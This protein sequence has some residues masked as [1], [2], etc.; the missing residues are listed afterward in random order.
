MTLVE[1]I[2]HEVELARTSVAQ[3]R[4]RSG[5][6]P[7]PHE[8]NL[9][10]C[11]VG[12]VQVLLL[13][14]TPARWVAGCYRPAGVIEARPVKVIASRSIRNSDGTAPSPWLHKTVKCNVTFCPVP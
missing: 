2:I 6:A 5:N 1:T 8:S 10:T 14:T 11:G 3:D 9:G 12:V 13:A 7:T 4:A